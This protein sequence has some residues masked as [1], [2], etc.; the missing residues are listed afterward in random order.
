M[1]KISV[2]DIDKIDLKGKIICF[3]TDTVYGVGAMI[4]DDVAIKKIY[5]LKKR[6]KDKPLAV[7]S[8]TIDEVLPLVKINNEKTYKLMEKWPGALT[9]VFEKSDK[10]KDYISNNLKTI[11]IRIPNSAI[12]RAVL[13][14]FGVL[15][16]T[17]VNIS[18]SVSLNNKDEIEK[19]FG[20]K[21]DYM[22]LEE[23]HLSGISSTVV[24]VM[25]DGIKVIR[26]GSV[27]VS[28]I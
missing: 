27:D 23:E 3:P 4:D 16:T 8:P 26:Q 11:G 14:R 19:A 6:D 2:N 9:I 13:N 20:D 5:D 21:I 24:I 17:S 22:I 15:A 25:D 7:L 1:I 10:V 28:N 18:G 12:A